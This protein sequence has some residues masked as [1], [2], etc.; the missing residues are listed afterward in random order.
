[1]PV[2]R[3]A[4]RAAFRNLSAPVSSVTIVQGDHGSL[5]VA[6][7]RANGFTGAVSFDVTGGPAGADIHV[8]ADSTNRDTAHVTVAIGD[9]TLPGAYLL[10]VTGSGL[11]IPAATLP[12]TLQVTQRTPVSVAVR[13]CSG[14]EPNW[15]A[16]QDG[17]GAWT[18]VQ[19]ATGGGIV[20]FNHVFLTNRGAMADVVHFT[21]ENVSVSVLS[22]H[23]GAPAELA[24]VGD[25]NPI[26]CLPGASKT[27]LG[28]VTGLGADDLGV[29]TTGFGNRARVRLDERTD[30]ALRGLPGG[31]TDLLATRFT[32][33]N[34]VDLL[35]RM[36]VRRNLQLP[37]SATLPV[38]DF[39]AAEAFSPAVANLSVAGPGSDHAPGIFSLVTSHAELFV[40]GVNQVTAGTRQYFALPETQL[41]PGEIQTLSVTA[42]PATL[43]DSRTA[44]LYF[45]SPTDH[46]ITLGAPMV[47]PTFTTLVSTPALRLQ[48][49]FVWQA[50]YDRLTAISYQQGR[51]QIALL[52]TPAYASLSGKGYALTVP[53]L[54]LAEGFDPGWAM[55]PGEPLFWSATRIGGTLGVGRDAVLSDGATRITASSQGTLAP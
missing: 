52:M 27:L 32:T 25:T 54:S 45:R 47:R 28:S 7:D 46:G 30:W 4:F 53:D 51:T 11:G 26:D 18:R 41:S 17:D 19:P 39:G 33:A 34:G 15:V 21:S 5:D 43:E 37:D 29:I 12:L 36:I 44:R 31:P 22:V 35:T 24:A 23:Y 3:T 16:F 38:L 13:Y 6:I 48:A 40:A 55:R 8:A 14:L 10:T 49:Q 42:N 2:Y 9:A 1:M 20:A 50:E